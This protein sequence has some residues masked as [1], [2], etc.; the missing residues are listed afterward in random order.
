MSQKLQ[1]KQRGLVRPVQV[2]ED[3]EQ[4]SRLRGLLQEPR[5]CVE[6]VKPRVLRL[7]R[8]GRGLRKPRQLIA[9]LG[10]EPGYE[11]SAGAELREQSFPPF[12]FEQRPQDLHPWPVRR[13]TAALPAT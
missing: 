13:G 10:D 2:V 3:E 11:R 12:V 1:E 5:G 9:Q 8:R 6:E 4:G 7:R